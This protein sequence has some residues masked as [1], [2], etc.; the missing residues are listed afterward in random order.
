MSRVLGEF[1]PDANFQDLARGFCEMD[2]ELQWIRWRALHGTR[3]PVYTAVDGRHRVEEAL[4]EGRGVLLWG[5]SFCGTLPVKIAL[6]RV[7]IQLVHLS[8]AEHGVSLPATPLGYQL[9]APFYCLAENRFLT[10]RVVIPADDSLGYMRVLMKRL[11][12][13]HVV[14]IAGERRSR[15]TNVTAPLFGH[16]IEFAPGAPSLSWRQGSP[17]LPVYVVRE[18][19]LR[20]RAVIGDRIEVN[21]NSGKNS[22]IQASVVRLAEY[23]QNQVLRYPSAWDWRY[24]SVGQLL[25][26]A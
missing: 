16:E 26:D 4:E 1:L 19:P 2:R 8:R 9:V 13:N 6:Q 20:Y 21:R 15:R 24:Y 17:L 23:I 7:G 18:G 22:F 25:G 14:Y 3:S 5:L 12:D 11:A 10:E